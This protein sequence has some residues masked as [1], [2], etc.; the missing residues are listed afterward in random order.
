[1]VMDSARGIEERAIKQMEVSRLRGTP[2]FTFVNKLD[3]HG[4]DPIELLDEVEDI[5]KIRYA[6]VTWPIGMGRN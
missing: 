2:I 3:R 6:P 1:M 4:R 5:L